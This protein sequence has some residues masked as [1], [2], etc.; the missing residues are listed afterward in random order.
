M[1]D[2]SPSMQIPKNSIVL[3][4]LIIIV[5]ACTVQ[6]LQPAQ[7]GTPKASTAS[8]SLFPTGVSGPS[9]KPDLTIKFVALEM[10]GRQGNC[11]NA[12][13]PYGIRVQVENIG[14]TDA[15][16]FVVDL[17][18]RR[19]NM[20]DG[21]IAG[22]SVVLFFAGTSPDGNYQA[23]ADATNQVTESRED[24]NSMSYIAPTPTPPPVCTPTP[25]ATR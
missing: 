6:P 8:P 10:E 23:V 2:S 7:P 3:L 4:L 9:S 21:L 19:Q 11:V 18:G 12:Y 1:K 24:N 14:S 22:Q 16:P 15:G 20:D 25:A 5:A 17:N 13:T